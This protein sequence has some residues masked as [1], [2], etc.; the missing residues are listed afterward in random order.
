MKKSRNA[1]RG[2]SLI[3]A[4]VSMA[5][6]AI[7]ILGVAQMQVLAS[8]QNGLARRTSRAAAIA[9][10]FVETAQRWTWDDPRLPLASAGCGAAWPSGFP[11]QEDD[12]GNERTPA[13]QV[14]FTAEP[15]SNPIASSLATNMGGLTFGGSVYTGAAPTLLELDDAQDTDGFQLGW[16][17][18]D[19]DPDTAAC[20]GLLVNVVVRYH[21]GVGGRYRN[22][23]TTFVQYNSANLVMAGSLAEQI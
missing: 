17:A 13:L 11:I 9:R 7:G 10:D 14:D 2:F 3:E 6:L 8:N 19:I 12:L 16:T 21:T 23:V 20:E 18:R 5:I 1:Q 4:M 15:N 22:F